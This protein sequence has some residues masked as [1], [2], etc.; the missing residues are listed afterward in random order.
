MIDQ[1]THPGLTTSPAASRSGP[2]SVRRGVPRQLRHRSIGLLGVLGIALLIVLAPGPASAQSFPAKTV[3]LVV[4]AAPGGSTDFT[5][6]LLSEPLAK[7]L[8][9]PVIVENKPGA[10]GNIATAQVARA[11]PDGYTLLVQ[12]SGYHVG[13]P[14][15][16]AKLDW[17]PVKDFA[18]VALALVAPHLV[19]VHPDVKATSL[20]QLADLVRANPGKISYASAGNGSIQHIATELFAQLAGAKMLHVPYKGAGPAIIDL[21]SGRV[22]VFNTTPPSVISHVRS[23]KLRA[24]AYTGAKRHPTLA[25]VPTSAEAGMPGYDVVSWFAVFAPAATPP[26]AIE[27]LAGEI[28]KIVEGAEYKRKA[29]EQGAFAAYMGPAELGAY[30]KKELEYWG[31]VIRTAGIKA[32]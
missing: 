6:R 20:K 21:V 3:T 2:R 28:R 22:E 19:V 18:P 32:D 26:P 16:F 25:D 23:G 4:G 9:Q 15:L 24:L 5:A 7:A 1:V 10:S 30:V 12:Y 27:R 13:N 31:N 29:E 11:K 17:D 14:A 8:G